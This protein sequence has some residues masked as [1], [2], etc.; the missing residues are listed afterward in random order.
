MLLGYECVWGLDAPAQCRPVQGNDLLGYI[1]IAVK[2]CSYKQTRTNKFF[3]F[4]QIYL[5]LFQR[6]LLKKEKKGRT[7]FMEVIKKK[8][9]ISKKNLWFEIDFNWKRISKQIILIFIQT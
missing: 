1:A 4:W 5:Y 3:G 7:V 9:S 8:N 2:K 6:I